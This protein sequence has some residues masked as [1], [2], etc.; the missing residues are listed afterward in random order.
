MGIFVNL[1]IA[2][3][4]LSFLL[5][6]KNISI[7]TTGVIQSV[8]TVLKFLPLIFA[9][10]IGIYVFLTT[11]PGETQNAFIVGKGLA[12]PTGTRIIR[13]F[14]VLP[15]VLFA[16]DSFLNVAS[17]TN[18]VR[19]GEKRMPLIIGLGMLVIAILYTLVGLSSVISGESRIDGMLRLLTSDENTK[20]ALSF[21]LN[22]FI[23][24][25]AFGVTNGMTA[26]L[27]SDVRNLCKL[28]V[29]YGSKRLYRKY[30]ERTGLIY[31]SIILSFWFLMFLT[32]SLSVQSDAFIDGFS[33]FP[34]VVF[35]LIYA[36]LILGYSFQRERYPMKKINSVAFYLSAVSAVVGIYLAQTM[37][38]ISQ[39]NDIRLS[40]HST[41]GWGASLTNG[42]VFPTYI[43]LITLL[44]YIAMIFIGH[45]T[46][47][48]LTKRYEKRDVLAT[49]NTERYD[50]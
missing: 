34:T 41:I 44:L 48:Y 15:A 20:S 12:D 13:V 24:I 38:F 4:L 23:F 9:V 31:T 27:D 6:V 5:F 21:T 25:S 39:I 42:L 32:I 14:A 45:Y 8:T 46:N 7:K 19:N 37:W 10:G 29:F 30:G 49:I 17:M 36:T 22:I 50:M 1:L 47:I 11:G 35:F 33:N 2:I 26:V 43:P 18:R 16:Y 28:G 3:V 40:D